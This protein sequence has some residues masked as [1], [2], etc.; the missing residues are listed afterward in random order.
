MGNK[1]EVEFYIKDI[2]STEEVVEYTVSPE[3]LTNQD[4][5]VSVTKKENEE[6]QDLIVQMSTDGEN[7]EAVTEKTITENGT[8]YIRIV[9]E[10][11]GNTVEGEVIE[12]EIKNI[13]KTAPKAQVAYSNKELTKENVTATITTNEEIQ[14]VEGWTRE[15]NR[16]TLTKEYIQNAKEEITIKDIVGNETKVNV[17]ITNIDKTAPEAQVTYSETNPTNKNVTATITANEEIQEVEGWT[18]SQDK[19]KLT[20]EY[21]ANKTEKVII[22]DKVGNR[23]EVEVKVLNI[24][25]TAP[26]VNVS[27][28]TKKTT[29]QNVRV[30]ITA[31]EKV[32]GLTGWTLSTDSKTLTKEYSTNKTETITIKDLAGNS[33]NA[34][35]EITNIDKTAP[36]I[37]V[38][39]STTNLTNGNVTVTVTANEE[40]QSVVGWAL[41]NDKKSITKTYQ[42]NAE[43]NVQLKDLAGNTTN[44]KISIK[45]IDKE[46]PVITGVENGKVY[47]DSVTPKATDANPGTLLLEK[48]GTKVEGYT[49]GKEILEEGTYKLTATD[50][51]GN[52]TIVNFTIKY[53]KGDLNENDQIDIGDVLLLLRHIAQSN[54]EKTLQKHPDWKLN[55]KRTFVGDINKNGTI[56]IGDVLKLRRYMAAKANKSV[57]NKHPDWLNID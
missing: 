7:Y 17:E 54:S 36:T 26:I 51:V 16:K 47:K 40:V 27:Y 12:V 8:V 42:S 13:D 35:I 31:S 57:S 10:E 24:D 48:D 4:V 37:N 3:G 55:E 6:Y 46:K 21:D 34:T 19:K 11:E 45:N 25:K 50:K 30:T 2:P 38:K 53:V 14:E 28:N 20:K 33:T 41:S 23:K 44:A 52:T 5:K 43:E 15:E 1:T 29:N 56:D 9:K 32:Q 18:I 22:K 39:H 49:N